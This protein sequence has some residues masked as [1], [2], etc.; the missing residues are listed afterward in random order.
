MA[1][2]LWQ[3]T[4]LLCL[5]Y[6]VMAWTVLHLRFSDKITLR[7]GKETVP[8][9]GTA[10]PQLQLHGINSAASRSEIRGRFGTGQG[11]AKTQL[12]LHGRSSAAPSV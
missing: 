9:D 11:T 7:D 6:S 5:S 4:V 8:D 10:M 2:E 1:R 3:M 12:K